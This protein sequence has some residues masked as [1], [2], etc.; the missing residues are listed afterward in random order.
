MIFAPA[1]KPAIRRAPRG[2]YVALFSPAG[3]AKRAEFLDLSRT[4]RICVLAPVPN[5]APPKLPPGCRFLRLTCCQA[6]RARCRRGRRPASEWPAYP[7]RCAAEIRSG[8]PAD[9]GGGISGRAVH[10]FWQRKPM[11]R[12][13]IPPHSDRGG[14]RHHSC[15]LNVLRTTAAHDPGQRSRPSLAPGSCPNPRTSRVRLRLRVDVS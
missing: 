10:P 11:R 8:T 3:S 7:L 6:A 9:T 5:A 13:Q 12:L 1:P 15:A 14:P 2:V 4:R